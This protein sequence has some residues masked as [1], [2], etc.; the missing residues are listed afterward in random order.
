MLS[1]PIPLDEPARLAA[2]HEHEIVDTPAEPGFDGL[3]ALAAHIAGTPIALISIVTSDRQWFKSRFGLEARETERGISFC[4][5]VVASREALLVHDALEDPRFADNPLV[6]GGPKLRFYAGFPLLTE[7]GFAL[8]TLCVIDRVPRELDPN[9]RQ[10]LESLAQQGAAQL[11][12][13]RKDHHLAQQRERLKRS[14]AQLRAV[15]EAMTEGVVVMDGAGE[16]TRLNAAADAILGPAEKATSLDALEG[17]SFLDGRPFPRHEWPLVRAFTSGVR[18]AGVLMRIQTHGANRC[19]SVNAGPIT[20][21]D[22]RRSAVATFHDVTEQVEAQARLRRSE[23]ALR[24]SLAQ[25]DTLLQEVHHRVK[26]NLQVVASLVN[27]QS[28]K[29]MDVTGRDLF[30]AT[31]QRIQVIALLHE[32]LYRAS[33]IGSI[34]LEAY[35]SAIGAGLLQTNLVPSRKITLLCESP[36]LRTNMD[37]AVPLGLI[38]NE[39]VSNALKH[40]FNE[41]SVGNIVVRLTREAGVATLLVSDDGVGLPS[42][43]EVAESP[44]LGLR[45]VSNLARQLD[46]ELSWETRRGV[47]WRLSFPLTAI[48]T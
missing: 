3:T 22:G 36:A 37:T 30:A 35:L 39:L 38:V 16:V 43:L 24:I 29:V 31:R 21:P 13:R 7:D 23:E 25:K 47:S 20:S 6:S 10:L 18:S 27:L 46:G 9:T 34:D 26:N 5:H 15:V 17:I 12:L 2:L 40:A 19:V 45:L 4:G 28:Q 32:H 41:R 8:G 48:E 14:E 33:D 11:E 1:A 44:S 42:E